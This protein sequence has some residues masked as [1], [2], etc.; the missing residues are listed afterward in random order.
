MNEWVNR[1]LG[2]ESSADTAKNRL[3]VILTYDRTDLSPGRLEVLRDELIQVISHH[4]EI[5][6]QA[7]KI[8]I[9]YDGTKQRLIA[10]I[11]LRSMRKIPSKPLNQ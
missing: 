11:P 9:T 1:V 3:Q 10:D 6:P 2:K 7:M 8:E 5:D 4:V